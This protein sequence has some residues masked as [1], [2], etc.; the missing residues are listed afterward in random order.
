[1]KSII[2]KTIIFIVILI[3]CF[4][5]VK[6]LLN[7]RNT[8][9]NVK[10]NLVI[11]DFQSSGSVSFPDLEIIFGINPDNKYHGFVDSD[12]TFIGDLEL[13]F[14]QPTVFVDTSNSN[15]KDK[16]LTKYLGLYNLIVLEE[17]TIS[18][19]DSNDILLDNP[20]TSTSTMNSFNKTLEDG[21]YGNQGITELTQRGN[22]L[23]VKYIFN[24]QTTQDGCTYLKPSFLEQ[25]KDMNISPINLHKFKAADAS[26]D[27]EKSAVNNFIDFGVKNSNQKSTNH[28]NFYIKNV[29]FLLK[30]S[31]LESMK[32]S[33]NES[34]IDLTDGL[35]LNSFLIKSIIGNSNEDGT[36]PGIFTKLRNDIFGIEVEQ[37]SVLHIIGAGN[38]TTQQ[39]EC[40]TS[41]TQCVVGTGIT[42]SVCTNIT[43]CATAN[44]DSTATATDTTPSASVS[45]HNITL[46]DK[47]YREYIIFA[48]ELLYCKM[49]K[50][51]EENEAIAKRLFNINNTDSITLAFTAMNNSIND[52]S[53]RL[54]IDNTSINL[55]FYYHLILT[56]LKLRT[57]IINDR[58]LSKFN[59]KYMTYLFYSFNKA[60]TIFGDYIN[61][62]GLSRPEKNMLDMFF[63]SFEFEGLYKLFIVSVKGE[64]NVFYEN[65]TD[66]SKVEEG[67]SFDRILS[68]TILDFNQ[69][70]YF[71]FKKDN[72]RKINES[73]KKVKRND[74]TEANTKGMCLWQSTSLSDPSKGECAASIHLTEKCMYINDA[75][76][77]NANNNCSWN[78]GICKQANCSDG[79]KCLSDL[80]DGN[81]ISHCR[82]ITFEEDNEIKQKCYDKDRVMYISSTSLNEK[83]SNPD[84]FFKRSYNHLNEC[85]ENM[86][87]T[88]SDE[89]SQSA[90]NQCFQN[91]N[92]N[93]NFLKK[94][95]GS[96][97]PSNFRTCVHDDLVDVGN[98]FSCADIKEE[99]KCDSKT[100]SSLSC[101]WQDGKCYKR[102]APLHWITPGSPYYGIEDMTDC[103]N[104]NSEFSCPVDR[105]IW[106]Y[107]KDNGDSCIRKEDH[108]YYSSEQVSAR[109]P[110]TQPAVIPIRK[111]LVDCDAINN[112]SNSESI[113]AS[114][115]CNSFKCKWDLNHKI[116]SAKVGNSCALHSSKADC[117]DPSKNYDPIGQQNMCR[118]NDNMSR[119]YCQN[120]TSEMECNSYD[121]CEFVNGRCNSKFTDTG[122]CTDTR[123]L[124]PCQ[125]FDKEK[126]PTEVKVDNMGNK[127]PGSNHCILNGDA[128]IN[129]PE[130]FTDGGF[131]TCHYNYLNTGNCDPSNCRL[132]DLYDSKHNGLN[133]KKCISRESMPCSM[134]SR[135]ECNTEIAGD[136]C[137]WDPNS[138]K[139]SP[140]QNMESLK[141]VLT[142]V[143][144]VGNDEYQQIQGI[145]KQFDNINFITN[146]NKKYYMRD[147]EP[148]IGL[149]NKLE[150]KGTGTTRSQLIYTNSDNVKK[151]TIGDFIEISSTSSSYRVTPEDT[152][153][154]TFK[155]KSIDIYD[156]IIEIESISGSDLIR[157]NSNASI[158]SIANNSQGGSVTWTITN[159]NL[160]LF[161]SYQHS[162][163]MIDSMKINDFYNNFF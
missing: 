162:Q 163:A 73:C 126:C 159:P 25:I 81:V 51:L 137:Y 101:F 138:R 39:T 93:C 47:M 127:I 53:S 136:S 92:K 121:Q 27:S 156:K 158:S 132:K 22:I 141:Q 38:Y 42:T 6:Y 103:Q 134:L 116:C 30:E 149:V 113:D 97:N 106:K 3:V 105:C 29:R 70:Y 64:C 125:L 88:T 108:P 139:C 133:I 75:N 120:K 62:I 89:Y 45:N 46:K 43:T 77:C 147:I 26:Q 131:D 40:S 128:C 15:H 104:F 9:S 50:S 12:S 63:S 129:N 13:Y 72:A 76:K 69:K 95:T 78:N 7:K 90:E 5:I 34:V 35:T 111:E 65:E 119:D 71:F 18:T 152:S 2:F 161:G 143:A 87:N 44:D 146:E 85:D 59:C 155:V 49:A 79:T 4:F 122:F 61:N 96:H 11:E 140:T 118:W 150:T 31:E 14:L 60:E 36:T 142:N 112:N 94:N 32:N 114:I 98:F 84:S 148:V 83:N 115:E 145:T 130:V 58:F 67:L 57:K 86:Y 117:L 124:Q 41:G 54:D 80:S 153:S 154:N 109:T 110:P 48:M 37:N 19:I 160:G 99:E 33:I 102:D 10:E 107:D 52:F 56:L 28:E 55:S 66:S 17:N 8:L 135:G 74:C 82:S 23:G 20:I 100:A 68:E 123:M 157:I 1:M 144:N 151:V 91:G 16:C 24:E 21:F